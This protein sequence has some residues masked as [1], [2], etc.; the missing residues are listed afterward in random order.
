MPVYPSGV[1]RE[2]ARLEHQYSLNA[3]RANCHALNQL[4]WLEHE[5]RK[6]EV[7]RLVEAR[8]KR[9]EKMYA[10]GPVT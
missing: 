10:Q 4:S 1:I 2:S 7:A 3:S 9:L 8:K 5:A 6:A